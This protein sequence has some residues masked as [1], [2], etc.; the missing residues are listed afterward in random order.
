M[1]DD[2]AKYLVMEGGQLPW[3]WDYVRGSEK[4]D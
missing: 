4:I 1:R 2:L 3:Q